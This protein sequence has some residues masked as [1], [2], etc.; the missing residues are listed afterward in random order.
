[1]AAHGMVCVAILLKCT[2]NGQ[3]PPVISDPEL[4]QLATEILCKTIRISLIGRTCSF[5]YVKSIGLLPDIFLGGYSVALFQVL[6][7]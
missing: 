1:M 2:E 6:I 4:C 3:W 7:A 5:L